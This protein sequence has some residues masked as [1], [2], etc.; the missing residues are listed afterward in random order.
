MSNRDVDVYVNL[1]PVGLKYLFYL[2]IILWGIALFLVG[3]L[4][5][6]FFILFVIWMIFWIFVHKNPLFCA[7]EHVGIF[8]FFLAIF[9]IGGFVELPNIIFGPFSDF[10]KSVL[11]TTT[12]MELPE[13]VAGEELLA[14]MTEAVI[15]D[16]SG[17]KLCPKKVETI[18]SIIGNSNPP[19]RIKFQAEADSEEKK[20]ETPAKETE[21]ESGR[22]SG[23]G[24][25]QTIKKD[26]SSSKEDTKS[27]GTGVATTEEKNK[28]K[29][30]MVEI[31]NCISKSVKNS[32]GESAIDNAT[33]FVLNSMAE[34]K[35][36]SELMPVG[37]SSYS[38]DAKCSE[39]N[40]FMS[41]GP[42]TVS[43]AWDSL[44]KMMM[45]G[46]PSNANKDN[47]SNSSNETNT[48]NE[49]EK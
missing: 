24:T 22:R 14:A 39:P 17:M 38:E 2:L 7:C 49:N 43:K 31:T 32:C 41:K 16:E 23:G 37:I 28:E 8:K 13:E 48:S 1:V 29:L 4:G 26:A 42:D 12:E 45:E 27:Q 5:M 11:S 20:K 3:L 46:G 9:S 10:I 25:D 47:S 15:I 34:Y 6:F 35:C 44:Y 40:S 33:A 18:K 30:K 19:V 36:Y 21:G